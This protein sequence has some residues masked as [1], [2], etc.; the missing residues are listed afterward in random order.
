MTPEPTPWRAWLRAA[1]AVGVP[2]RDFWRLSFREWRCL[3]AGPD[4]VLGAQG[5]SALMARY[6]DAAR[7][8]QEQG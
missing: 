5:L 2:P 3:T 7:A 4:A 6:P 1:W 8:M